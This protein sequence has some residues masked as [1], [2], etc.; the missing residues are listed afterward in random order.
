MHAQ[1][2]RSRVARI[3]PLR[4]TAAGL[5][6][7][8][9]CALLLVPGI[10]Y[11]GKEGVFLTGSVYFTLE[12]ATLTGGADHQSLRFTVALNN[13]GT[14]AIDYN[15]FGVRVSAG[16]NHYT[17]QLSRSGRVIVAANSAER[18]DYVAKL[19]AGVDSSQLY[20]SFFEWTGSSGGKRELG[21]LSAAKAGLLQQVSGQLT[22]NLADADLTMTKD[23]FVAIE[24]VRGYT[25]PEDGK[26]RVYL[27]A[28]TENLGTDP[29]SPATALSFYLR[30]ASGRKYPLALEWEQRS[31]IL[32]GQKGHIVLSAIF[33]Q[34]PDTGALRFDVARSGSADTALGTLSVGDRFAFA[35]VGESAPY[36]LQSIE[37]IGI[38]VAQA[39]SQRIGEKQQA[40]ISVAMHNQSGRT[41]RLP[42][43]S[44]VLVFA[45]T[46]L[47]VE[48]APVIVPD[49]YLAN[50]QTASYRFAAELPDGVSLDALRFIVTETVPEQTVSGSGESAP[51]AG[52]P[53]LAASLGTLQTAGGAGYSA[54]PIELDRPIPFD[55]TPTIPDGL[56]IS[57]VNIQSHTH[58]E[59]GYQ[60]VVAKFKVTN[61]SSDT[62]ALPTFGSELID[63]AGV[64][65]P[66]SRQTTAMTQLIPNTSYVF[67]YSYLV[68]PESEGPYLLQILENAGGNAYKVPIASGR[69][70]VEKTDGNRMLE[71][72]GTLEIYPFTLKIEYWGVSYTFGNQSYNYQLDLSL[73]IVKTDD[74]IVDE[75]F[76]QLEFELIDSRGRV[77]GSSTHNFLGTGKLMSGNHKITFDSARTDQIDYPITVRV[78]ETIQTQSG[79][80]KRLLTTLR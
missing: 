8:L 66:G 67:S 22:V 53:V 49:A 17:A 27:L 44:G 30:D 5:I 24:A 70:A 45:D 6:V 12:E 68:P 25:L 52:V 74:V 78:Y 76:S 50:G 71:Q 31:S 77:L 56:D 64:Y 61:R 72:S 36:T 54:R 19:P 37:G 55:D 79:T 34:A 28:E 41:V 47:A 65:Y 23:A 60:T 75:T 7:S 46:Q 51:A 73:D 39:T 42:N 58:A 32:P 1:T 62:L 40:L 3:L 4:W 43:L 14:S 21:S 9:L 57:L 48:A 63:P 59:N 26:W 11:A 29:A 38:R 33:D 15:R 13:G 20:V 10:S 35:P 16:S 18:Y 69:V 80:A 2:S